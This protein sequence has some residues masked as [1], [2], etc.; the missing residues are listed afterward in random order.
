MKTLWL[1][2]HGQTDWNL[3]LR[4][5]GATDIPLNDAGIEQARQ[6]ASE[7]LPSISQAI[8]YSSPLI[9]ARQT[10]EIIAAGLG[11]EI[12][13]DERLRERC[14]GEWEGKTLPQLREAYPD[15]FA[16]RE[17]DPVNYRVP[18]SE[19]TLEVAGRMR[20]FALENLSETQVQNVVIVSHG[21]ALSTL[22]CLMHG[23]PLEEAARHIPDN[24]HPLRLDWQ[25]GELPIVRRGN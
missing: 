12:T 8:V 5:Q 4:I 22:I 18:G 13:F 21:Y 1:I 6:I 7:L 11:A 24:A 20:A 17:A 9:R 15:E 2:R 3:G 23:Y 10:A 25:G 16:K 14:M 19:T